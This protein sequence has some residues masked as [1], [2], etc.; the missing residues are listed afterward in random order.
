MSEELQIQH[1]VGYELK[2]AQQAL[3]LKMDRTL[4]DLGLTTPQYAALAALEQNPGASNAAL[5]RACFM[6]PQTMLEILKGLEKLG[7][8]VRQ[9]HPEHGRILRTL[10]NEEG[11]RRLQQAHSRIV[12]IETQM[13]KGLDAAAQQQLRHWLQ[14][15]TANLEAEA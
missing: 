10:L 5:A 14:C 11:K 15:C 12:Q 4:R 9:A 2:R 1:R 13:L 6:T 3:R 7:W 8:V